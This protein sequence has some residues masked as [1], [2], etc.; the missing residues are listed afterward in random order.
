M[1]KESFLHG[2]KFKMLHFVS[3]QLRQIEYTEI[4]SRLTMQQVQCKKGVMLKVLER[5]NTARINTI[6]GY[7]LSSKPFS[8]LVLLLLMFIS[9]I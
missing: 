4:L 2:N 8:K 3:K 7:F 6:S 9:V 1:R 5:K